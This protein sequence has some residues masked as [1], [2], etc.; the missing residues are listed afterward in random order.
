MP[1]IFHSRLYAFSYTVFL[2]ILSCALLLAVTSQNPRK[3]T[4]SVDKFRGF[5]E[6]STLLVACFYLVLEIDQLNK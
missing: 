2:A 3:Y 6:V 4:S 5:C 1:F